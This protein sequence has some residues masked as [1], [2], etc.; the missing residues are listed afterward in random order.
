MPILNI[1]LA[2]GLHSDEQQRRLLIETSKAFA[3]G[4]QS[5]IERVRVFIE[6]HKPQQ[7]A[8]GGVPVKESGVSAPYFHFIVLKGRSLEARHQL[9]R[10]FTDIIVEVLGVE[11]ALVRGGCWPIEPEDWS[12]GGTPAS[13]LRATE[14]AARAALSTTR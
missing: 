12:I 9:I 10:D 3:A 6:T 14:V 1:H 8:V 4:L 13:V 11:R 5:P 7:V 2:E